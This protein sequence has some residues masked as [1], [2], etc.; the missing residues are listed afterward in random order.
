M[1][2]AQGEGVVLDIIL[3]V[4]KAP[5][6]RRYVVQTVRIMERDL[7]WFVFLNK[8][9]IIQAQYKSGKIHVSLDFL[10]VNK[11]SDPKTLCKHVPILHVTLCR[12]ICRM[13]LINCMIAFFPD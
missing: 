13:M 9:R 2:R 10:A 3:L 11:I 7:I 5:S 4:L 8:N 12:S 1:V 6:G